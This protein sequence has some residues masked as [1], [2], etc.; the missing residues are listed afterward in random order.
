VRQTKKKTW[1]ELKKRWTEFDTR[2]QVIDYINWLAKLSNQPI[3]QLLHWL[4][5]PRSKFYDWRKRYGLANE[6]NGKVPRDWWLE[7][8][9][10]DAIRR[11]FIQ[12]PREGYRRLTYMMM[13]ED[14][15]AC[16]PS[17]TY[18]FL[19]QER[20]LNMNNLTPSLKGTGFVQPL[21]PH[22]QWHIDVTYLNLSGTFYY[23]CSVLDGYSRFIVQ[24]EIRESMKTTNVELII[25]KA[26]EAFPEVRPTLIS[27]NGPQFIARDM[28]EFI[29]LTGM[30]HVRTSP[31][32]P[33][34]NGK[35]ERMQGSL[36]R[37]CIRERNPSSTKE[38]N[39]FVREWVEYYNTK[40]LHSGIGYVAP[41]DMLEGRAES[42]QLEREQK[43]QI[44]R[45]QRKT[46][47]AQARIA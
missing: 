36:K 46:N 43:L 8:G 14:I 33:Q 16:A 6:H 11:F 29:R 23:L 24:W 5:L 15:V 13:D 40:R 19:K 39:R 47:R 32:Y 4:E 2:D 20:L 9:E 27:D 25:Q 45:E 7:Q 10:K 26:L 34:S 31:Y 30:S 3:A 1:P 18:R 37:E 41:Q 22:Q 38:A 17:T 35:Q 42:I 21:E 28:K 44:A 12:H